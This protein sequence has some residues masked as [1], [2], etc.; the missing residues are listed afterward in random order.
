MAATELATPIAST[1]RFQPGRV[2]LFAAWETLD[3]LDAWLAEDACGRRWAQ[4]WHVR[5][6]FRC[7]WGHVAALDGLPA[8]GGQHDAGGPV[9]AVTLARL[10][11]PQVPRC[12]RRG[13]PV[14]AKT[15]T[16]PDRCSPSPRLRHRGRCRPSRSGAA[17][18]P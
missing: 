16:T 2:A 10:K 12:V 17:R 8:Y 1:R 18:R 6:K 13:R 7:R 5:L 4:G 14:E 15:A 11:L 3:H 9:V